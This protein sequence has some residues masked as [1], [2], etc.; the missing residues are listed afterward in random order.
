MKR[1][2]TREEIIR[3]TEKLITRNGIRAV[4]VDE[5]VQ[6]VGI[7]KRTLYEM[8]SDKTE[9]V[10]TCLDDMNL[11]LQR[12]ITTGRRK[13]GTS[14][15]AMLRLAYGY[16]DSL[17]LVDSCFLAEIS[18]KA[19]FSENYNQHRAFW[20]EEMTGALIRG[21]EDKLLN[22]GQEAALFINRMMNILFQLRLASATRDELQDFCRTLIRGSSTTKGIE[23]IDN[24]HI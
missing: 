10:K 21:R 3:T 18:D 1:G 19:A 24:K 7:S 4:R 15:Q 14:L 23:Q 8:F 6:E 9:L 11:R 12:D 2:A 20:S 5:I 22:T 13:A 16:V 17:Y